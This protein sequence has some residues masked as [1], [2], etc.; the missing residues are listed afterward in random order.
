MV[1]TINHNTL[2][3][4]STRVAKLWRKSSRLLALAGAALGAC[5]LSILPS[6]G[7]ASA[8]TTYLHATGTYVHIL[9][10][11]HWQSAWYTTGSAVYPRYNYASPG[12]YGETVTWSGVTREWNGN[13]D[14]GFN[15]QACWGPWGVGCFAGGFRLV[16]NDQG[17]VINMY[18]WGGSG[19]MTYLGY[20]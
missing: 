9:G 3:G 19:W 2:A 1:P 11:V 6:S 5:C 14:F 8:A 16:V 4:K 10:S 15:D 12:G 20:G 18:S 13:L 7:P 17:R